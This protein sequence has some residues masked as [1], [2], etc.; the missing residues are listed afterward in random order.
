MVVLTFALW[1]KLAHEGLNGDG[2]E[3][4]E[5]ARSLGQN[6]LPRWDLERWAPPGGSERPQSIHS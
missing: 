5:L 1:P 4:Y 6:R 2:T 3:A